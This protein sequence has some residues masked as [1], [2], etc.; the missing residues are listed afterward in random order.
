MKN[1][2]L[3]FF[4]LL[5]VMG[6][7]AQRNYT[8][9]TTPGEQLAKTYGIHLFRNVDGT[10]FDLQDDNATSGA[11]SYLNILDWLQGRVAGL[12]VYR[13]RGIPI[14][15]LRNR[16]ATIYVDEVRVD[17]SFLNALSTADVG[18]VKVMPMASLAGAYTG[19]GGAI[20]IYTRRGEADEEEE[21]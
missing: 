3:S 1:L 15:F 11:I 13:Y 4:F 14:P 20:A 19:G 5:T 2:V 18:L 12:Q 21:Q 9:S 7:F 8:P 10:W 16:P 6:V 17:Y